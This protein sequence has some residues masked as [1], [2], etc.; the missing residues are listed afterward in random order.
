MSDGIKDSAWPL[1]VRIGRDT[2]VPA[3]MNR[4]AFRKSTESGFPWISHPAT[5]RVLPWPGE[6]KIESLSEGKGCYKLT[7]PQG[8]VDLPYGEASPPDVN[9]DDRSAMDSAVVDSG[10][11]VMKRLSDLIAD[12]RR[13]MPEGSY[14]THLFEKGLD[15]IRKKT[16]E[17]AVELLLAR[18]AQDVIF[19]SADLIYHLLVL[20]EASD[21]K[22]SAVTT[23][24]LRRHTE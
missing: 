13:T 11:S 6:P 7:I 17:E 9:P 12:R 3:L 8:S 2:I 5:G 24:L 16:G 4:K 20:L 22:W 14:T 21:L 1:I 15:K 19:E 23:E 18:D 10:D